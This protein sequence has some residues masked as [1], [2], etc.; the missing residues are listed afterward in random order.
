MEIN[1]QGTDDNVCWGN[2]HGMEKEEVAWADTVPVRPQ[3][4]RRPFGVAPSW[5]KGGSHLCLR[6]NQLLDVDGSRKET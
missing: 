6:N 2:P 5:G 4:W 3:E 1:T